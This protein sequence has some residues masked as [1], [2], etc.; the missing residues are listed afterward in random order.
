MKEREKGWSYDFK[1]QVY[2]STIA[3]PWGWGLLKVTHLGNRRSKVKKYSLRIKRQKREI[4]FQEARTERSSLWRTHTPTYFL[5][6]FREEL[7]ISGQRIRK[8]NFGT[9]IKEETNSAQ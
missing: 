4:Q 9:T 7:F 1:H 2:C 8:I 5:R 3:G 6:G